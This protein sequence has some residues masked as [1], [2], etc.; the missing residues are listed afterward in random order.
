[1]LT[2]EKQAL[3]QRV[4]RQTAAVSPEYLKYA[5]QKITA[6]LVDC[7]EYQQARTVMGFVSMK[8]EADML[9]FLRRTLGDGKRLVV[10]LCTAPGYME[11]RLING[12][13]DLRPGSYGILEPK[14]KCPQLAPEEIEFAVIP[15]VACDR[16]GNR[17]GHGGGYYDRYLAMYTGPAALVCPEALLQ[18]SIPMEPL[19]RPV[20]LVVT[21]LGIYRNGIQSRTES[22]NFQGGSL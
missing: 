15:C 3:R 1:M 10:P 16:W 4:R 14:A 12:M 17:L 18:P 20:G 5:G 13:D 19:D 22:E 21:E 2:E 6:W 8:T 9:P 7:P 11:A